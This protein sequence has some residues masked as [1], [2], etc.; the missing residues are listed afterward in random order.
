[1]EYVADLETIENIFVQGLRDPPA[2]PII[3]R[4]RLETF[5]D[6]AFHNYQ[7]LLEVH[8]NLLENLQARQLE[9]HPHFG[10]ISDL[11]LD[12]A[13]NW[14]DAYME[15]VTHYPIAKAKVQEEQNRNPKFREFL[16]VSFC[17]SREWANRD[18]S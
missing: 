11:I 10:M 9:Q 7:S 18:F 1:M 14:Q 2:H 17:C 6:D 13:L 15:Y 4:A 16:E 5:L 3:D 8:R 12:A